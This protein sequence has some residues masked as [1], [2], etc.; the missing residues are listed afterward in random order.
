MTQRKYPDIHYTAMDDPPLPLKPLPRQ[1]RD[2]PRASPQA[3]PRPHTRARRPRND[4]MHAIVPLPRQEEVTTAP[5][6]PEV[7]V[8]P[9]QLNV[10]RPSQYVHQEESDEEEYTDVISSVPNY[11]NVTRPQDV[12]FTVR[13]LQRKGKEKTIIMAIIK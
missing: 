2:S 9:S 8:T 5:A 7:T 1:P 11:V 4:G 12:S 13:H 3:S 6:P 10:G